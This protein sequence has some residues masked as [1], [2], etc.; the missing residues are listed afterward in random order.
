M[1]RVIWYKIGMVLT[2][3][4]CLMCFVI[5]CCIGLAMVYVVDHGSLWS[6]SGSAPST[7]P[8][9]TLPEP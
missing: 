5:F 6:I 3:V 4:T 2:I 8:R 7:V 9:L 1:I